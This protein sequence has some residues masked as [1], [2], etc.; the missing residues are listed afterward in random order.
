MRGRA[1]RDNADPGG[2][3]AGAREQAGCTGAREQAGRTR[4]RTQQ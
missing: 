3:G 1:A 4:A 2:A